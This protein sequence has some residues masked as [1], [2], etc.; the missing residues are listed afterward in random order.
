MTLTYLISYIKDLGGA[1]RNSITSSFPELTLG[2]ASA[3]TS[4]QFALLSVQLTDNTRDVITKH[5]AR[6]LDPQNKKSGTAA[7]VSASALQ[8]QNA[9]QKVLGLD[10]IEGIVN[11]LKA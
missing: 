4:P 2:S 11:K 8:A 5:Q 6:I 7:S 1:A 10:R 3:K 9:L